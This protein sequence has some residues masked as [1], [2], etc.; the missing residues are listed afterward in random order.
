MSLELTSG[1]VKWGSP[2]ADAI[3]IVELVVKLLVTIVVVM[4]VVLSVE[5]SIAIVINFSDKV[6]L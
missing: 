1:T 3:L 2:D 5:S 6:S 4:L